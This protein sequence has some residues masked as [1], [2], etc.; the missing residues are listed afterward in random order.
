MLRRHFL[1]YGV[2]SI[3]AAALAS[4]CRNKQHARVIKHGEDEMVG[5]HAAGTETFK[6][7]IDESVSKLLGN[8]QPHA[9]TVSYDGEYA[10]PAAQRIC[11]VGV[12]NQSSEEIADFKQQIYQLIDTRIMEADRFQVVNRR[13]VDAGLRELRLRPEQLMLPENMR[14]FSGYLEQ[15]GQPFDYLLWAVLTSG[16][17]RENAEYQRDYLLTLEL[18]D[19]RTGQQFKQSAEI[20]K[21]YHNSRVSRFT[22]TNPFSWGK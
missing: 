15:Q 4:G 17:T 20:S 2:A 8:C 18:V 3:A 21:G 9:Q 6:P 11:F 10:A 14:T 5:S 1:S 7:L 19:I 13:Y 22:A 12:E 16:T